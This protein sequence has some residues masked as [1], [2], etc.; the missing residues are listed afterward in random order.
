MIKFIRGSADYTEG[1]SRNGRSRSS[2]ESSWNER[3]QMSER[4]VV[5]FTTNRDFHG[6]EAIFNRLGHCDAINSNV[7]TSCQRYPGR[8]FTLL[9]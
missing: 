1:Y 2:S 8:S 6:D 3:H 9:R 7:E 5:G 4:L